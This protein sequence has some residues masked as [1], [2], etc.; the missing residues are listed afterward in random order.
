MI[1]PGS[2]A[3]VDTNVL[4]Y[5]YE[6]VESEQ[7]SVARQLVALLM[8]ENRLRV[9]TQV[10]QELFVR[11]TDAVRGSCTVEQALAEL[12]VIATWPVLLLNYTAIRQAALLARDAQLS[13][14]DALIVV[15]AARSGATHL[16]TEDLNHGQ[17]L[18][19]VEVVNPFRKGVVK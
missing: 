5:A 3:F 18:L 9:S 16:Y 2:A 14:W 11:L 17:K 7:K 15:A 6:R 12:D 10:L 19:G 1:E 13:F 4:V 8:K